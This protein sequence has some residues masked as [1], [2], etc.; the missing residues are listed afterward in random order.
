[1]LALRNQRSSVF[2]DLFYDL[3]RDETICHGSE[4]MI[5]WLLYLTLS[6]DEINGSHDTSKINTQVTENVCC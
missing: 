3:V 6:R 1:M 2:N 5:I 4:L